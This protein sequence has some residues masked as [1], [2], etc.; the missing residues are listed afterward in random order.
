MT[1]SSDSLVS[2]GRIIFMPSTEDFGENVPAL[3][4]EIALSFILSL[5]LPDVARSW[6]ISIAESSRITR[7]IAM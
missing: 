7:L 3:V 2:V 6:S 4:L 1:S 5:G